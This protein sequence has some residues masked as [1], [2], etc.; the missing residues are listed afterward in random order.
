M[1][2]EHPPKPAS[3]IEEPY[4][5]HLQGATISIA[6]GLMFWGLFHLTEKNEDPSPASGEERLQIGRVSSEGYSRKA[7]RSILIYRVKVPSKNPKVRSTEQTIYAEINSCNKPRLDIGDTVSLT[8]ITTQE[9]TIVTSA[10]TLDGCVLQDAALLKQM[11]ASK[12]LEKNMILL[13]FVAGALFFSITTVFF[14]IRRK[15]PH[16]Q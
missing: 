11:S 16:S 9:R 13:P 14:W 10:H 12:K 8:V 4:K 1:R 2:P 6:L 5:T 15:K 7:D 3:K